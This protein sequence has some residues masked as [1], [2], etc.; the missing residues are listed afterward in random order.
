MLIDHEMLLGMNGRFAPQAVIRA[1]SAFDP[2]LTF[3][4]DG[5]RGGAAALW[6]R[7]SVVKKFES[8]E[9]PSLTLPNACVR[10][11]RSPEALAW[12]LGGE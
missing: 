9:G 10:F 12:G 1:R 8:F 2:T 6:L 11:P 7:R 4:H 5:A 3:L